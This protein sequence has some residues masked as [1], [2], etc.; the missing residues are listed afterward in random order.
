MTQRCHLIFEGA[1]VVDGTGASAFVADVAVEGDRIAAVG[2]LAEWTADERIDAR[3]R[4]LSPGFIDV[5]THDDLAV[6][7]SPDM[8]CKVSQGV[9]SVI[10]GNCGIS[11]APFASGGPF[12]APLTLL[13]GLHD[14]TYPTVAAYRADWDRTPASINLAL[15][16]G[17]SS[18]RVT[19]MGDDLDRP[20]S[21]G[22][23]AA[24]ADALRQALL[25][26]AIG[27]ST[28]LD[29]PPAS[30]APEEEIIALA[31]VL[32]EVGGRIYT[33]HIRDEG[34]QVIEA[35]EE[36]IHTGGTARVRTVVSH[37]KCSGPKNYGRS[38]ETL[39]LLNKARAS[40][41]DIAL[42]VYPYTA[43]STSLLPK[44][45]ADAD[46]VLITH[47]EPHP[48]AAGRQLSDLCA[49]WN[50]SP[51]AVAEKL[52]P[53]AAIYFQMDEGDLVRIMAHPA[54]MIG[55]DGLPGMPNPHP[56][57]WG[58]FPRVL[59]RYVREK[60]TL[61]LEQA[62]HKM[63]GLSARTF[64]LEERGQIAAGMAADL[65][66]FNPETVLDVADYD[67]PE[68]PSRGIE[69]VFVNGSAVWRD[70]AACG[71]R[72]GRFLAP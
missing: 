27:F 29:Y 31:R 38:V 55:S 72:P 41:T 2:D 56:R 14:F 67:D 62:I 4:V 7:K 21:D 5:H 35:L 10:A 45:V 24:M 60:K 54:A 68:R 9:T 26:G 51:E 44:Y 53:A 32:A 50:L 47:S 46:Q 20:A 70:G 6:F 42:D 30:K 65:V 59:G 66:L 19:A 25:D 63:T 18:L 71:N 23:A 69:A 11:V 40:G 17:H 34:D 61:G 49:E 28:G 48:E 52:H 8:S 37:H 15:L 64:G 43:S 13:G 1:T 36:A 58:T 22:E 39:S 12:P 3:G 16:V 57:L 33:S